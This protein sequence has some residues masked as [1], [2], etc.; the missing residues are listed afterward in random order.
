MSLFLLDCLEGMQHM[1]DESVD[2][3]LADLP[4]AITRNSWDTSIDLDLWWKHVRRIT[5]PHAAVVMT[6][7]EPFTS[8]LVM[9]NLRD[10]RYD[11]IWEK[12]QPSGFLNKGR[13]PL[14]AHE[15]VLVFYRRPPTYNPQMT[16]GHQRKTAVRKARGDEGNYGAH[17]S[18]A[19]D[20]T[21]R[22]PRS[23]Q[24]FAKDTQK[25]A[26]SKT[27]KPAALFAWLIRTYTD[28]GDLVLD[29]CVGSGTTAIAAESEDRRWLG[30]ENDETCYRDAI[31]RIKKWRVRRDTSGSA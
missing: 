21:E 5:K 7:A 30:F 11:L 27:Q 13:M 28:P 16:S 20:S 4:Y 9:S 23:V 26:V 22:Y 10:F 29:T 24:V 17:G 18:S 12:T 14:R 31:D 15:S 25:S 2:M 19:Y 1:D 3:V 6:A 8:A